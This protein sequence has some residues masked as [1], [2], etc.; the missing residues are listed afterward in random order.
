MDLACKLHAAYTQDAVEQVI[1]EM[2]D[3]NANSGTAWWL[4]ACTICE[5][6]D[7]GQSDFLQQ[8]ELFKN[9]KNNEKN[10][11][12]VS[13]KEYEYM[14]SLT[15]KTTYKFPYGTVDWAMQWAYLTGNTYGTMYAKKYGI[16]LVW[17]Y[18][19][20]LWLEDYDWSKYH[21][22]RDPNNSKED[23]W[24]VFWSKQ[25]IKCAN[26]EQFLDVMKIV[27]WKLGS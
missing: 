10:F 19:D 3:L 13:K 8:I 11:V 15:E 25:F 20:S 6:W 4:A 14:I 17:T 27:Q 1:E 7:I 12:E 26:E 22:E 21:P 5:K 23:S 9:L 24:P 18:K 16:Y 2:K